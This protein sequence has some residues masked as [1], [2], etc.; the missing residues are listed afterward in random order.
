MSIYIN[1]FPAADQ[2]EH[3]TIDGQFLLLGALVRFTTNYRVDFDRTRREIGAGVIY[4]VVGLEAMPSSMREFLGVERNRKDSAEINAGKERWYAG[5]H[6]RAVR[7]DESGELVMLDGSACDTFISKRDRCAVPADMLELI[8]QGS[9]QEPKP[10][11]DYSISRYEHLYPKYKAVDQSCDGFSN[12]PTACLALFLLN[13][14]A[15]RDLISR[16]L[17][18]AGKL[19]EAKLEQLTHRH[20]W[21]KHVD[22]DAYFTD[23]FPPFTPYRTEIDY[24]EIAQALMEPVT[25]R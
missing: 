4:R 12:R 17:T 5:V 3:R 25:P 8:E 23:P 9:G 16:S 22:R 2:V 18:K 11:V 13:D 20:G 14:S 19:T 1:F 24:S 15:S 10:D 21:L 6:L 7:R